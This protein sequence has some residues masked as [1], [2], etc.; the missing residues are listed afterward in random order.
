[1]IL[2]ILVNGKNIEFS[3]SKLKIHIFGSETYLFIDFFG[4]LFDDQTFFPPVST[5]VKFIVAI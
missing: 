1:M 3:T 4:D 2:Q 5:A